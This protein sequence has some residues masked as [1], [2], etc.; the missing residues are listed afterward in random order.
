VKIRVLPEIVYVRKGVTFTVDIQIEN[1]SG[2]DVAQFSL[3]FDHTKLNLEK[4]PVAGNIFFGQNTLFEVDTSTVNQGVLKMTGARLTSSF[5]GTGTAAEDIV[6][7]VI[8]DDPESRIELGTTTLAG[9][10]VGEIQ[11]TTH[12]CDVIPYLLDS[13]SLIYPTDVIAGRYFT[14]TITAKNQEGGVLDDYEGSVTITSDPGTITHSV[15]E[16]VNGVGVATITRYAVGEMR[17][18]VEDKEAGVV[19]KTGSITVRYLCDF[20]SG[21]KDESPDNKLNIWDLLLFVK[22]W[23]ENNP[24][25]DVGR[26]EFEG[27]PPYIISEPDG[28]IDVW[29]ILIFIK[30]WRWSNQKKGMVEKLS[31]PTLLLSP[32]KN[33]VAKGER[34]T[35]EAKIENGESLFGCG[36]SIRYDPTKIKVVDVKEGGYFADGFLFKYRL[37]DGII[38]IDD[39]A[40]DIEKGVG[41]SGVIAEIKFEVLREDSASRIEICAEKSLLLGVYGEVGY[42]KEDAEVEPAGPAYSA[43]FQTVPNPAEAGVW[44]PYQ[45]KVGADCDIRIYNILGQVVK[46]IDLGYKPRR[47][48]KALE[49]GGAAYWD[50]TN[51]RGEKVADGLYFYQLKA[52]EF[53]DTKA[54]AIKK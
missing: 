49:P 28:V 17:L 1:V 31:T 44:I 35:V 33:E 2:L 27:E 53:S 45:L 23:R 52:G 54:M 12:H 18:L 7:C 41:G 37:S 30:M 34:F 19:E 24:K 16:F 10:E 47:Y 15:G 50:L 26:K 9:T 46:H 48:Y 51:D 6:F 39:A 38:T 21:F 40:G 22:Y 42:T 8:S 11:H 5:S 29:D 4:E 36:L 3:I 20:G 13:F 43:L 14:V 32:S 25:G